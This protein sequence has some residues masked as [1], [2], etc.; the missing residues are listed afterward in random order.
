MADRV[1]HNHEVAGSSPAPAPI[2]RQGTEDRGRRAEVGGQTSD[3]GSLTAGSEN[4][5][6]GT[7]LIAGGL[8][9]FFLG[10]LAVTGWLVFF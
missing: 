4:P 1:A 9:L 7:Y 6:A 10:L 5:M 8:V 2:S 3:L